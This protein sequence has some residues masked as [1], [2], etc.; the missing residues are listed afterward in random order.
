MG[1]L[2]AITLMAYAAAKP[3]ISMRIWASVKREL[4]WVSA[5]YTSDG[6]DLWEEVHSKDFFWNLYTMRK[7]L[8][9]GSN[10]AKSVANDVSRVATYADVAK[11]IT[12][13]LRAHV[14]S[15]GF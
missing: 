7:A 2:R 4:D 3:A 14:D 13:K 15:Q 12:E 5:N 8:L 10:F 9:Q 1:G 11:T 6:C